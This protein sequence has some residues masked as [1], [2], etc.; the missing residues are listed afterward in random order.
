MRKTFFVW[1]PFTGLGL[2]GGFRGNR[3]LKNRITIFK[4]FV[5]SSLVA[6]TDQDFVLWIGWRPEERT[7]KHVQELYTWLAENTQF[8]VVFTYG[9]LCM[10]DDKYPDDI[11]RD[12]LQ[13]A[14]R[15]T[16]PTLMD[17]APDCEEIQVL[18]QPSDDMYDYRTIE[19]MKQ[20]FAE[21]PELQ[22]I[23]YKKGY[24]TNYH[25]KEVL[26]YNP[27]TNPPFFAYRIPREIFFDPGK[28]MTYISTKTD[29][30]KYKAGTP[31]PSHEWIPNAFRMA[32]LD[33]RGFMV[34]THGENISTH[35]NHPFGGAKMDSSVLRLFGI[36]NEPPLHLPVSI[37]KMILRKLPFSTQKK[38]RYVFG[39]K[40]FHRIYEFLRS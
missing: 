39:E 28:H 8:K 24:I 6:Q 19:D 12:R 13:E 9:G 5:V 31:Y 32:F 14:F 2:Y 29:E 16:L 7:N 25:S 4:K 36:Y 30:G 10:W 21:F 37:R 27:T 17:F 22:A 15:R 26:E 18:L 23:G 35:F 1:V 11:A 38:L 40:L 33:R 3:W 20:K 34:G